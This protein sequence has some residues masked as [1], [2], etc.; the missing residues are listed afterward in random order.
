MEDK[1]HGQVIHPSTSF[2]H[3]FV[4]PQLTA[5]KGIYRTF[6]EITKGALQH[7]VAELGLA[8]SVSSE[9]SEQLMKAYDS[10]RV[11][12]EVP[13]ALD[14]VKSHPAIEP[15]IFSNGTDAMVGASLNLSPELASHKGLFKSLITV[16]DVQAFKPDMGVYGDL[17]NKVGKAGS[18]GDVWLVTANPF[19]IVGARAAGLQA[20][21][22]DRAGTGWVDRLGNVIGGLQ[23]T[24]VVQG[25]D[26]AV[27]EIIR[28][29]SSG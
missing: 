14:E 9:D 17:L 11:F 6:S 23:P 27:A 7:A 22:V 15:Y 26:E 12:P 10:L 2:S 18:A 25:V 20:A 16:E 28:S 29:S 3:E 1:F 19:D 8:Q 5:A 21:W 4:A 24:V 13:K